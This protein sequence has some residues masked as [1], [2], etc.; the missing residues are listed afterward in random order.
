MYARIN[1]LVGG[2]MT[3]R[4]EKKMCVDGQMDRWGCGDRRMKVSGWVDG[5]KKLLD[6]WMKG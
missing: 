2:Q 1:R 5:Q 3:R 4:V 6:R